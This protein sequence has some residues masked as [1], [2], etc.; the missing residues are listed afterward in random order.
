MLVHFTAQQPMIATKVNN[1]NENLIMQ[2]CRW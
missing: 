1:L 2:P